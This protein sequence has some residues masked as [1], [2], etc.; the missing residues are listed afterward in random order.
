MKGF[1]E[2]QISFLTLNPKGM[3]EF[4]G[5]Q[6]DPIKNG[7]TLR[8]RN[9]Q[10]FWGLDGPSSAIGNGLNSMGNDSVRKQQSLWEM[11]GCDGKLKDL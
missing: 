3:S 11:N 8:G 5:K 6:I 4:C 9:E 1:Y 10:T 2:K 7:C